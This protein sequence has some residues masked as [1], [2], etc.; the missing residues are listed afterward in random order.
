MTKRKM[1]AMS[2]IAAL[3]SAPTYQAQASELT[4]NFGIKMSVPLKAGASW[5]IKNM[6]LR[7]MF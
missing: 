7:D 1:F 6:L 4:V 2:F 5:K 3:L